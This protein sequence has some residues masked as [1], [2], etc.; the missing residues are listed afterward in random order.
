MGVVHRVAELTPTILGQGGGDLGQRGFGGASGK[1]PA[2]RRNAGF[3]QFPGIGRRRR[4]SGLSRHLH[5]NPTPE[6][7]R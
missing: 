4:L 1:A 6:Q 7:D 2:R 3:P 5:F